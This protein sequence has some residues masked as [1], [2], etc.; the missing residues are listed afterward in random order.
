MTKKELNVFYKEV[1]KFRSEEGDSPEQDTEKEKQH[2]SWAENFAKSKPLQEI[3]DFLTEDAWMMGQKYKSSK[4]KH[5]YNCIASAYWIH[6]R[7][8]K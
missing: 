1:E 5:L 3:S 4:W 8:K 2:W 6:N 7:E